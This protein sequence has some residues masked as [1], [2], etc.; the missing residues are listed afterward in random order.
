ML[1]L[2][3]QCRTISLALLR[4]LFLA[5]PLETT[6]AVGA[7]MA[8]VPG[9]CTRRRAANETHLATMVE[10]DF[11][12]SPQALVSTDSLEVNTFRYLRTEGYDNCTSTSTSRKM[13]GR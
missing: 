8:K 6:S 11:G 2:L 12:P 7:S 4:P 10:S 5:S 1:P 13:Q 9:G 3:S